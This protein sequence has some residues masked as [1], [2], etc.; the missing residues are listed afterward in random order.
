MPE[1]IE[2]LK[3]TCEARIVPHTYGC[4]GSRSTEVLLDT[5]G[6][7]LPNDFGTTNATDTYLHAVEIGGTTTFFPPATGNPTTPIVCTDVAAIQAFLTPLFPGVVY[8]VN[9]FNEIVLTFANVG[10]DSLL[11]FWMGTSTPDNYTNKLA[12]TQKNLLSDKYIYQQVQVVKYENVDGTYI[13]RFFIPSNGNLIETFLDVNTVFNFGECPQLK[14]YEKE[15]CGTIDGSIANYELIKVYTRD[16]NGVQS[17]VHYET[18]SGLIIT[19]IVVET[20]CTCESLCDVPTVTL[21]R[22]CFGYGGS[23][24]GDRQFPQDKANLGADF[25]IEYF[26]VDGN[27]LVNTSTSIGSVSPATFSD[28]GYGIAYDSVVNLLNT[29]IINNNDL[30][31]VTAG[32]ILPDR[33]WGIKYNSVKSY[34]I[35]IRDFIPSSAASATWTIV[36]N[37]TE[38]WDGQGGNPIS[39]GYWTI[40]DFNN[41]VGSAFNLISCSAI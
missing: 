6:F 30:E 9:A 41:N 14:L 26:E 39:G 4:I 3:N 1:L 35:V 34:R 19:G 20:C 24:N 23:F 15:V 36:I 12:V 33:G 22:I 7:D 13:D 40:V 5:F 29:S 21:N 32:N 18:K 11:N 31:F 8:T 37:P 27:I 16:N 38:Q 10:D 2:Y 28:M 17:L 25:F